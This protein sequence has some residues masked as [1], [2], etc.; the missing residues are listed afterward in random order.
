M[1]DIFMKKSRRDLA[2]SNIFALFVYY[3]T[4][5]LG[6]QV[7]SFIYIYQ[8]MEERIIAERIDQW[9]IFQPYIIG[10]G[11]LLTLLFYLTGRFT[12]YK[13]K[14]FSIDIQRQIDLQ[15]IFLFFIMLNYLLFRFNYHLAVLE[16]I[17]FLYGLWLLYRWGS[18]FFNAN[19]PSWLHPTTHG[20]FF[21]SAALN[22]CALLNISGLLSYKNT[23]L[24]YFL[25][26][27]LAFE[28]FILYARFKYLSGYSQETVL[29]ARKLMGSQI[30]YFGSRII[31][32]IFM[33]A[34]FILYSMLFKEG[35]IEGVSVLLLTGTLLERFIFIHSG[36]GGR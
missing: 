18:V 3:S 21:I 4:I 20:T 7:V 1:V 23:G 28:L 17:A 31:I 13:N 22:G 9:S 12:N 32:G 19:I 34:I 27:L 36:G 8:S 6:C 10:I 2:V 25:L 16:L 29:I 15:S 14:R 30:L 35:D 24:Q 26:V 33:P 5:M 11:F